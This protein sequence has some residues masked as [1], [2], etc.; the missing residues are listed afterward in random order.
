MRK[1]EIEG[2]LA[3]KILSFCNFSHFCQLVFLFE[4]SFLL[5]RQPTSSRHVNPSISYLLAIKTPAM[6]IDQQPPTTVPRPH[7]WRP[8]D[9][10]GALNDIFFF[11]ES[12][13]GSEDNS[14]FFF[15]LIHFHFNPEP[16]ALPHP[17]ASLSPLSR[18]YNCL[19]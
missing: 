8:L 7:A 14:S 5:P 17:L 9:G 11:Y 6:E 13:C 3:R 16:T 10:T 18:L 1:K 15:Q 2:K 19:R 12:F 4:S